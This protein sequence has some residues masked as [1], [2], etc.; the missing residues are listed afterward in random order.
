MA[1]TDRP[2]SSSDPTTMTSDV[3]TD[4]VPDQ[5]SDQGQSGGNPGASGNPGVTS[6][7]GATGPQSDDTREGLGAGRRD[8]DVRRDRGGADQDPDERRT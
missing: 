2:G 7:S 6:G 8:A 3:Q 4:W 1:Q 5:G